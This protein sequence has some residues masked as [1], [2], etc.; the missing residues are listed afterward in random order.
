[1][2]D[3]QHGAE[4]ALR[5]VGGVQEIQVVGAL[6]ERVA[7]MLSLTVT[8]RSVWLH[9][10]VVAHIQQQR[11]QRDS[12]FVLEHMTTVLLRPDW[13]G[14]DPSDHRRHAIVKVVKERRYS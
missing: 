10:D 7:E 6:H 9:P 3:R 2:S 8:A 5:P 4:A 1:M 13:A 14:C 12:T 11:G